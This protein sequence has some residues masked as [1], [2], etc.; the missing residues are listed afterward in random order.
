M[1]TMKVTDLR[2]GE[3]LTI[4]SKSGNQ[5]IVWIKKPDASSIFKFRRMHFIAKKLATVLDIRKLGSGEDLELKFRLANG[6]KRV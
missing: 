2:I 1:N 3:S 5:R 4:V 6:W